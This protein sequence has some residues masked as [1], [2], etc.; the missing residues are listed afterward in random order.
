MRLTHFRKVLFTAVAVGTL[1]AVN[2]QARP[3]EQWTAADV[4]ATLKYMSEHSHDP[5]APIIYDVIEVYH[6]GNSPVCTAHIV[7]DVGELRYT[8]K[9][10]II[11]E[12]EYIQGL[13]A[14]HWRE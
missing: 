2:A 1:T 5:G 14:D 6:K 7:A 3:C 8:F 9:A 10:V 4:L 13:G 12:R 11:W